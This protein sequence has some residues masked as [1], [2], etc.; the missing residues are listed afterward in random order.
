[1]LDRILR[2]PE[3][4]WVILEKLEG[5]TFRAYPLDHVPKVGTTD[6]HA[7]TSLQGSPVIRI[8]AGMLIPKMI[9]TQMDKVG[10]IHHDSVRE[11]NQ[12]LRKLLQ[13]ESNPTQSQKETN[14]DKEYHKWLTV[15]ES[16][17]EYILSFI[18]K[19]L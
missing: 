5:D 17:Q 11:G 16:R 19:H 18:E 3:T 10:E 6:I 13:G 2:R 4:L 12:H 15:V 7:K 8:G 14:K 1:L 9:F